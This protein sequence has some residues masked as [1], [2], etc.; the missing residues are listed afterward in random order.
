MITIHLMGGLGNQL[1]QIFAVLAYSLEHGHPFLFPYSER[2]TSGVERPTYWDTLFQH[3][4][5]YTTI[6]QTHGFTNQMLAALPQWREPGFNYTKIPHILIQQNFSL[7]GYFQ[8]PKYF[9]TYKTPILQLLKFPEIQQTIREQFAHD[10][11]PSTHTISMHF[12]LGDYKYKQQY[13]PVMPPDYYQRAL[14]HLLSKL[15]TPHIRVLYFCEAEDN[16]YVTGVIESLRKSVDKSVDWVKA[17]DTLSDWQQLML[18]TCCDSHIIANSSF[19]W[20]GAYLCNSIHSRVCYPST[21]FGPAIRSTHVVDDLFPETW[22][23][24]EA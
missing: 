11:D 12:R 18:M 17:D 21:W 14:N 13:H 15:S 3:I 9:E 8:S 5:T 1:F 16:I 23:K 6:T 19:S 22:T 4:K 7:Y 24:I 20:W 10:V 2:L